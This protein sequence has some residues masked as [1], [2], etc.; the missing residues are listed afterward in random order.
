MYTYYFYYYFGF[1]LFFFVLLVLGLVEITFN[2]GISYKKKA[3]F[4]G[5]NAKMMI[6]RCMALFTIGL[7]AYQSMVGPS[8]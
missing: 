1:L 2:V 7:Y 3:C 4:L 8:L 6:L 5:P